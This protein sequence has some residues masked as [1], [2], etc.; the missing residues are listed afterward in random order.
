MIQ[1]LVKLHQGYNR[2][3]PKFSVFRILDAIRIM[4]QKTELRPALIRWLYV[5][6]PEDLSFW[7]NH[8]LWLP[9]RP[10]RFFEVTDPRHFSN[11]PFATFFLLH[12]KVFPNRCK[13]SR[14]NTIRFLSFLIL[15]AEK[16]NMRNVCMTAKLIFSLFIP[17]RI[18]ATFP[19]GLHFSRRFSK[20]LN[21]YIY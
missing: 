17:T 8:S 15:F 5:T 21:Y 19:E 18:P 14:N 6:E 11:L 1:F 2:C 16:I 20:L 7:T 12:P 10:S 3:H 9:N 4:H 13:R